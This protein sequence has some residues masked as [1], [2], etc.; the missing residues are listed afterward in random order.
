MVLE[1]SEKHRHLVVSS[2]VRPTATV[3][4]RAGWRLRLREASGP[5][6]DSEPQHSAFDVDVRPCA[7]RDNDVRDTCDRAEV[8]DSS[9]CDLPP[10]AV[11]IGDDSSV[12]VGHLDSYVS[13]LLQTLAERPPDGVDDGLGRRVFSADCFGTEEWQMNL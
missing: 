11:V 4:S 9:V 8:Q 12:A 5:L 6:L 3:C 1:R 7:R 2:H 10:S 13:I